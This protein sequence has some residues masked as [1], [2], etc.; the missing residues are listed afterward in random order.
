LKNKYFENVPVCPDHS[1]VEHVEQAH[2]LECRIEEGDVPSWETGIHRVPGTQNARNESVSKKKE[3]YKDGN[4][5]DGMANG[6]PQ[7]VTHSEQLAVIFALESFIG[8][9]NQGGNP[10]EQVR[11]EQLKGL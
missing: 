4:L 1:A 7:H 6:G 9:G 8:K 2:Q 3:E 5:V 11:V 10:Q